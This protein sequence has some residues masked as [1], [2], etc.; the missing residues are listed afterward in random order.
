M[1]MNASVLPPVSLSS[2]S[3]DPRCCPRGRIS[4]Q[5]LSIATAFHIPVMAH[6]LVHYILDITLS[7]SIEKSRRQTEDRH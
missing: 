1:I 4:G 6:E 7:F 2:C 3:L 5:K